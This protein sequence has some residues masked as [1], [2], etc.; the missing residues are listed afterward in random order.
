MIILRQVREA[1]LRAL[2]LNGVAHRTGKQLRMALT[3]DQVVLSALLHGLKGQRLITYAAQHDDRNGRI[4]GMNLP[5]RRQTKGIRQGEIQEDR[6]EAA[7]V[8]VRQPVRERFGMRDLE[9][10]YAPFSQ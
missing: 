3:F 1:L 5:D 7:L 6:V 4:R 9:F 2:P 10:F 8:D